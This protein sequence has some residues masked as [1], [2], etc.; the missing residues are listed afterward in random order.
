[1]RIRF[2][3]NNVLDTLALQELMDK[4]AELLA[5]AAKKDE[6]LALLENE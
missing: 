4:K 6:L 3:R 5:L 2:Q 1:M